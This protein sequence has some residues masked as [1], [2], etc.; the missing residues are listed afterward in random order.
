MTR[1]RAALGVL[2][3]CLLAGCGGGGPSPC[4]D[5]SLPGLGGNGG[6]IS[7]PPPP[8][9]SIRWVVSSA[10]EFPA[11]ESRIFTLASP[12]VPDPLVHCAGRVLA[13]DW[14]A[15]NPAVAFL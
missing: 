13:I 8:C 3:A 12:D 1:M 10:P 15:V 14:E 4:F 5:F 7:S 9:A 11:G 6:C 2:L